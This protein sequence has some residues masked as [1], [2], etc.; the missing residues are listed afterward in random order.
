MHIIAFSF[1]CG[2]FDLRLMRGGLSPLVW[3]LARQYAA[4]GHRVSLVTPAHGHLERLRATY[5]VEDL[6][7]RTLRHTVPLVPDPKTWTDRPAEIPLELETTAHVLRLDGV[8]V[9]LLSDTHLDL[10]PDRLYPPP[11]AEG[12]DLAHFKPLVFQVA[13][14]RYIREHLRTPGE[15]TVVHAFEPGYHYLLPPVFAGDPLLRTVSTVAANAPIGL[16]VYR[17]Q[18]ERLLGLFGADGIDLDALDGPLPAEDSARAVMGR[19]LAGTRLHVEYGPDHVGL[20][21]LV[22]AHADLVDFVS[23]GQRA[24]FS[25]FR[26]APVEALFETLPVSRVLRARADRLLTGGCGVTDSWLDRDPAAVDRERIRTGLGLDPRRPVFYHAARYAVHHKGQFE[27]MRAVEAVLDG[28]LEASFLIRCAA[29]GGTPANAYFRSVAERHPDRLRLS[30]DFADEDTLFQEAASADFCVFPSKFE[31]DGFLIAQAEAMACGAVPVATDQQVTAHFRHGLP[32]DD[33]RATGFSV[34]GSFRDDDPEL[35]R[36]LADL[37]RTAAAVHTERPDTYAR[38]SANSRAL[39]R[40]FTWARAAA[41]RLD[42]F[43]GLVHDRPPAFPVGEA[44]AAGWFDVLPA[45][46]WRDAAEEIRASA[47]T[48]G[49]LDAF[50][51][52]GGVPDRQTYERLFEAAWERADFARCLR[53]AVAADRPALAARVHR[54]G[55]ARRTPDGRLH[56]TYRHAGASAVEIVREGAPETARGTLETPAETLASDEPAPVGDGAAFLALSPGAPDGSGVFTGTLDGPPLGRDLVA[57]VTLASGRVAWDTLPLHRPPFR[58][59]ATDLDGT[60]LRDDQTVSERTRRALAAV[61]DAGAHHVVVTGRPAAACTGVLDAL[62]Y[63]GLAVCGQGAQLYDAGSG[64][65]LSSSRLPRSTARR[66]VAHVEEALGPVELGVVTA[67]PDSRFKVTERFGDR[68]RHGWD[69]TA[70]RARLWDDPV[71]K[72]ILHHPDLPEDEL[73]AAVQELCGDRATVVHSVRGMVEVLPPGTTKAV[74]I[75]RAARLLGCTAADTLAFGDMP[76]D[77]PLL[78]WAAHGVAVANAHPSLLAVAD[79]IAPANE[80]DGVARVLER[81]FT[82]D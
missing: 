48:H 70:D 62:G 23:P 44:V 66:I 50:E 69:V 9:H 65:L 47:L 1:E 77:I 21:P 60:L 59:V 33:P 58:L 53:T 4:Q 16:K 74:G 68:I 46:A 25:T 57:M 30:W 54:R 42:A 3:Q 41:T 12:H 19:A 28:G 73:A 8:D 36:R 24:Y 71:D 75:A 35:A 38:L 76:N 17:P 22:A 32:L 29:P 27:L 20:F 6:P 80:S 39:A 31:L 10:L 79:E 14:L 15:P 51:R 56:V 34:P 11:G 55:E 78:T 18:V 2:G 63:R 52:A 67:P 49:D 64:R 81:L 26:D 40:G 72:L 43:T 7:E 13:G 45:S 37:L 5:A 82:R 61:A